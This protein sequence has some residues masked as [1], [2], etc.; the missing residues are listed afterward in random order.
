MERGAAAPVVVAR[1]EHPLPEAVDLQWILADEDLA[2]PPGHG[3]RR[4]HLDD[5][6]G[7]HRRRV[8]L[9][10]ADDALVR[11]DP[12]EERILRSVGAGRVDLGQAEDDRLDVRDLHDRRCSCVLTEACMIS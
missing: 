8:G 6:P 12:E 4:R 7:Q 3:V 5:R 11:V 2:Q 1:V 9:A 10:D